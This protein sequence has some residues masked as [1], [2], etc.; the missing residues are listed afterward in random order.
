MLEPAVDTRQAQLL[1]VVERMM[2]V[3]AVESTAGA[4]PTLVFR[5]RLTADASQAWAAL[6]PEFEKSSLT[7]LLRREGN[8]D[9]AVGVPALAAPARPNPLVNAALFGLT[10]LSVA[11]A[12]VVNGASY[13]QPAAESMA[14]LRLFSPG[15][16]LLGAAFTASF[17]G[18][19]LAHEF[20]HYVA[21]RRH[22]MPVSLPYFI[23]FPLSPLG[24][25]GAAIRLLAP[26]RDRRV[27]LDIGMAGPLAGL[28]V[29]IPLLL[30]GLALSRV[31][32][33]PASSLGFAGLSLEG[34]SVIYLLAKLLIKGELLPAPATYGAVS[35]IVYWLRYVLMGVPAPIG[36]RDVMLHP[37]AWAGWAGLL[38]TALNLVPAGMFDGG[39]TI[40]VLV[41][42]KAARLL[43]FLVAVLVLLGFAWTGWW[44]WAGLVLLLGR[45][46]A[47]P[48]NDITPLDPKRRRIAVLGL[49]L[50]LLLFMPVPFRAFGL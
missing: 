9:L 48:L 36:G 14:D 23:P 40:Y 13:L 38:I 39:H 45:T 41:G 35:P 31:E 17:L 16:I 21:A 4:A 8:E 24:T 12:G 30:I 26:P 5:G 42:R 34:N 43:P 1:P 19:L 50:F 25:M 18:I 2:S 10:L 15:S 27:L 6:A 32:P 3:R 47:T 46:Y 44:L 37:V 29:A 20:G 49:V 22:G 7:L 28:A 33:L 11:Y